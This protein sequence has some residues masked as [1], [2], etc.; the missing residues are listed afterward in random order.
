[1]ATLFIADLHLC[2]HRP[3]ITQL[4]LRFLERRAQTCDALYILGDLFEY[5]IGDDAG[6]SLG[7]G[8][9]TGG[10]RA[11]TDSGVAV[12]VMHG[13]RD[14]LIGKKFCEQSGCSLLPDPTKTNLYGQEILLM[15][16]DSLCTDDV[17]HQA[18]RTRVHTTQWQ[19]EFLGKPLAEREEIA[20]AMRR[21][22]ESNK[23]EKSMAMMDVNQTAVESTMKQYGVEVLI[24]GHTHRPAIHAFT[25]NSNPATRIVLGDWYE[26]GSVLVWNQQGF[27]LEEL[28]D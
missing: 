13:N 26:Q 14:F 5:W 10:I 24:H 6:T 22:S 15:H 7:Y 12:H 20:I 28:R 2:G 17:A 23:S 9:I 4:F 18:F 8:D 11:L 21:Q 25:L 3:H 19:A 27:Q 1:M 16:G